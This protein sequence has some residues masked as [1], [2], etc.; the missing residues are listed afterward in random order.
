MLKRQFTQKTRVS[1][2]HFVQEIFSQAVVVPDL[3][4][5]NY[6]Q[7]GLSDEEL[8]LFL[9]LWCK[10]RDM[11]KFFLQDLADE[12]SDAQVV[13]DLMQE[14]NLISKSK[15]TSESS[16]SLE[17]L[18]NQLWE[19][20]CYEKSCS[21]QKKISSNPQAKH[22][23]TVSK[24]EFSELHKM[25]EQE[26]A[27][28]LSPIESEK[29]IKWVEED[30]FSQVMI[31]EALT[32]AVLQGKASL[33]YI[34]RILLSWKKQNLHTLNDVKKHD[35]YGFRQKKDFPKAKSNKS[36]KTAAKSEYDAVYD[37]LLKP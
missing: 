18:M 28:P 21:R 24:K 11:D 25:F 10:V 33:N 4:L 32:R 14:K 22:K 20:W 30:G 37:K 16:Y 1:G 8:I 19:I 3:L 34:D 7:M 5:K 26:F 29:V 15:E 31:K 9:R 13:L 2:F 36:K 35:D 12:F 27:R 17:G 23:K 6:S